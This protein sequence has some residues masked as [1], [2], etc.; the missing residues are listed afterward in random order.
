MQDDPVKR[1]EMNKTFVVCIEA[2]GP[3]FLS[4]GIAVLL[5]HYLDV[6]GFIIG[7]ILFLGGNT[8]NLRRIRRREGF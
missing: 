6:I 3:F 5:S 7:M 4:V 8:W 1:D 2:F